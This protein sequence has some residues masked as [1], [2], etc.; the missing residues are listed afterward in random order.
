MRHSL[1]FAKEIESERLK[2]VE[3]LI[4]GCHDND[5][6]DANDDITR[7]VSQCFNHSQVSVYNINEWVLRVCLHIIFNFFMQIFEETDTS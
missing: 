3:N 6:D 5:S 1:S 7:Y 4:G 2:A